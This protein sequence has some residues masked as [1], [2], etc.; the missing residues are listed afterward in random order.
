MENIKYYRLEDTNVEYLGVDVGLDVLQ[1]AV[2]GYIES[3]RPTGNYKIIYCNEEGKIQGLEINVLAS[4]LP[5]Q[6]LVGPIIVGI[7]GDSEW[8]HS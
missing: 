1:E 3:I 8:M 6:V 7:D 5:K 4:G 2:G